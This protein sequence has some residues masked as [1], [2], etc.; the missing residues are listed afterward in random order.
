MF[1]GFHHKLMHLFRAVPEYQYVCGV[2]SN[3]CTEVNLSS[4]ALLQKR[5]MFHCQTKE[6]LKVR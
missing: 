6:L 5:I 3:L 2:G 4:R 1:D